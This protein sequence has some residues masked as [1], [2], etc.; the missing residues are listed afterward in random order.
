MN[1]A[2]SVLLFALVALA[3]FRLAATGVAAS[4]A[5]SR[6]AKPAGVSQAGRLVPAPARA[7][8]G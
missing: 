3:T 6:V 8:Q 1:L 4:P 7:R 2:F 5:A